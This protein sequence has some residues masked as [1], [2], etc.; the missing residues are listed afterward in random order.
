MLSLGEVKRFHNIKKE[1]SQFEAER[2]MPKYQGVVS[3]GWLTILK[4]EDYLKTLIH[5][6]D[7]LIK[8]DQ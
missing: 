1:W 7:K 6:C 5:Y 2:N 4:R 3:P 8:V